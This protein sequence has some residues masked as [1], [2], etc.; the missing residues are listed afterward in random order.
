MK[1]IICGGRDFC[2][3][4]EGVN[5]VRQWLY[6]N[7]PELVI[8]GGDDS[9]YTSGVDATAYSWCRDWG[10]PCAVVPAWWQ[11]NGNGAGPRRNSLMLKL[12]ADTC[13]AFP[14]GRGTADMVR[15]ARK[16]GL[17]IIE[18]DVTTI[19]AGDERA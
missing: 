12:G 18:V 19:Q 2:K 8:V 11:A 14:G 10:W 16:A 6:G 15:K 9:T 4:L 5:L 3:T 13:V 1:A 17:M 7:R